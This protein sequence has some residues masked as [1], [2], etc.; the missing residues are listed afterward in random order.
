M[1]RS[2][3]SKRRGKKTTFNLMDSDKYPPSPYLGASRYSSSSP[4][5]SEADM[6]YKSDNHRSD[7]DEKTNGDPDTLFLSR[8]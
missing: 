4:L 7:V 2:L 3:P 8:L 5:F 6:E 1:N